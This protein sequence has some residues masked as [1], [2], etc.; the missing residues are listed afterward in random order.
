MVAL[1]KPS[2][3]MFEYFDDVIGIA[4]YSISMKQFYYQSMSC[5]LSNT[6]YW[7]MPQQLLQYDISDRRNVEITRIYPVRTTI[8]HSISV[9][10]NYIFLFTPDMIILS[11]T[12][13]IG[14]TTQSLLDF[15]IVMIVGTAISYFL[16]KL[17]RSFLVLLKTYPLDNSTNLR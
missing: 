13:F 1:A 7:G 6:L 12:V 2:I 11:D 9:Q 4:G 8:I 16:Y 5:Y 15:W 17:L 10:D 14:L 3:E